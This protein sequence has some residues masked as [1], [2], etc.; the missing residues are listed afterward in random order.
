MSVRGQQSVVDEERPVY[1]VVST[2]DYAMIVADDS[3]IRP[4]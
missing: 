3:F 2:F 4:A 1:L